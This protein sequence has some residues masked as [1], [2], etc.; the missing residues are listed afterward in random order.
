[1]R[2]D[3]QSRAKG[4]VND[5]QNLL[6]K[7]YVIGSIELEN[8]S[9]SRTWIR[10]EIGCGQNWPNQNAQAKKIIKDFES[11]LHLEVKKSPRKSS[12]GVKDEEMKLIMA[13]VDRLE[14]KNAQLLDDNFKYKKALNEYVW[15]DSDEEESQQ[16][17]LP[18]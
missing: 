17:K 16:A 14:Q 7:S 8:G 13:R 5:L 18:W 11:K 6:A 4:L 3:N 10:K 12:P 1:M 15:I 2:S 9:I